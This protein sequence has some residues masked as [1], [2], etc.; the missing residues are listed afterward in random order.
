MDMADDK[1][2][3]SIRMFIN[4]GLLIGVV[5]VSLL[6]FRRENYGR[7]MRQ[8][9]Q[10][11]VEFSGRTTQHV[12]D[13]FQDKRDS[14]EGTAYLY[15]QTLEAEGKS[16]VDLEQLTQLEKRACFDWVRY[17]DSEGIDYASDGTTVDVSNRDYYINGMKGK[18]GISWVAASRV[19]G[20]KLMGFY[21]PV[22]AGGQVCGVMVGFLQEKTITRILKTNLYGYT[23]NT[24]ILDQNANV[25]GRN[26]DDATEDVSNVTSFLEYVPKAERT[27]VKQAFSKGETINFSYQGVAGA[28]IACLKPIDGTDWMLMQLFPSEALRDVTN[29]VTRD[30]QVMILILAIVCG[31]FGVQIMISL[32]TRKKI[33][34][35][36]REKNHFVSMLQSVSDDYICLIDVDLITEQEQQFRMFEGDKLTDWAGGNFDYTHC[37]VSYANQVVSEKDRERFIEATEISRLKNVLKNKKDFFIE[38]EGKIAGKICQLQ[39]K[40][41]LSEEMDGKPHML[42]G[43]RDIT[44]QVKTEVRQKTSMDLIVSAASS[45]YPYILELNLSKNKANTIYNSGI[46]HAGLMES[47][48]VDDILDRLKESVEVGMDYQRLMD[49]M[50]R[51]AQMKAYNQGKRELTIRVRQLGDDGKIHWMEVRNILMKN[52]RG[53]IFAVSMTRCVDDEIKQTLDLQRAKNEAESSNRA[54]STFLFNMSHDIRTPMNAIMGFSAMAEKYVDNPKKVLDCLKKIN[55]SGE[56]L[57][58]LINDV[59][60]MSRIESGKLELEPKA[61]HVPTTIKNVGYIFNA[62]LQ[63]KDLQFD[64]ICD[65]KDE[66]L[67]FDMVRMNQVELNLISNAIKY[68]PAGGKIKYIIKQIGSENGYALIRSTVKDTGIGMSQEFCKHVFEAFERERSGSVSGIEGSGLGLAITKRLI[69][70]MGGRIFCRSKQGEGSEFIF[71]AAYKIGTPEDLEPEEIIT[72]TQGELKGKRVLLVEDNALNREIA[73]EILQEEG[74]LIDEADDGDEAVNKVK[75]SEPGYYDMVLMDI[76]MPKMDGYESTRRIRALEGEYYSNLPI[77]AVTANAFEEDKNAALEA[78][79]NGHIAKPIRLEEVREQL[80]KWMSD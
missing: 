46:V 43:I 3:L 49:M 20:E 15:G 72:T 44:E 51:T 64:L 7:Q 4:I 59:L 21:A 30:E 56:H 38:Y 73:R 5:L 28:S 45:V 48:S 69:E 33:E 55:I 9:E 79:M 62:D 19:S 74:L 50:S 12:S 1:R 60:D 26:L 40:F 13:M 65:L 70:Q 39:G 42:V 11:M 58:H 16:G 37:I 66:I 63:K 18:S 47:C 29:E 71:E 76:Q 53:D 32:R 10:F 36:E 54:K 52:Q 31:I 2:K 8:M 25:L 17:V 22:E 35:R 61:Y 57:L 41:T 77:V 68:T 27:N 24:M 6:L 67:F 34:N 80:L 14:I 23:A 78:G 75:W